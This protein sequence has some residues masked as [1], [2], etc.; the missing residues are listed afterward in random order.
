MQL[1][2]CPKLVRI[3]GLKLE[4]RLEIILKYVSEYL[5]LTRKTVMKVKSHLILN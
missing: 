3:K 1:L 4:K 5:F 2:P